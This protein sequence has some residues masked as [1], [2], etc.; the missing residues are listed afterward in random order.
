MSKGNYGA[1][2]ALADAISYHELC[3]IPIAVSSILARANTR[4]SESTVDLAGDESLEQWQSY[5]RELLSSAIDDLTSVRGKAVTGQELC[6]PAGEE[7]YD[8]RNILLR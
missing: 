3:S 5:L 4:S 8:R 6:I 1:T 2:A 7:Q